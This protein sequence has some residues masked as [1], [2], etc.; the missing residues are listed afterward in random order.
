MKICVAFGWKQ[1]TT[2]LVQVVFSKKKSSNSDS[3]WA[4]QHFLHLGTSSQNKDD[5]V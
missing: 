1:V 2:V 5:V 3:E 4:N